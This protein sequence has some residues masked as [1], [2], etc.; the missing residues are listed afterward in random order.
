MPIYSFECSYCGHN[1][2]EI[3]KSFEGSGK[4]WCPKCGNISFKLPS[5][6]QPRIFKPREFV[7]GTKTPDHIR[8]HTQEKKYNEQ[9]KITFDRPTGKEKRHRREERDGRS[10]TAMQDAFTKANQ[11]VNDGFRIPSEQ[12]P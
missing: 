10:N 9:N 8:T 6:A 12:K 7:D 3:H 4:S 1:F 5:L 11:K 2:D